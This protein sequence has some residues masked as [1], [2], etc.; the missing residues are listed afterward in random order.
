MYLVGAHYSVIK[1]LI[2]NPD[3]HAEKTVRTTDSVK[4]FKANANVKGLKK[5]LISTCVEHDNVGIGSSKPSPSYKSRRRKLA[6]LL[7]SDEEDNN[8]ND[9]G[10]TTSRDYDDEQQSLQNGCKQHRG[11]GGHF[12]PNTSNHSLYLLKLHA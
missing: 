12:D 3:W 9:E 7:E 8:S 4:E 11:K 10:A 5:Y 2:S 6:Q 1:T